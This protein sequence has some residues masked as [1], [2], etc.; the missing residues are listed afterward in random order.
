MPTCDSLEVLEFSA[1]LIFSRTMHELR[2]QWVKLHLSLTGICPP[3]SSLSWAVSICISH[4]SQSQL[5]QNLKYVLEVIADG[6][7]PVSKMKQ[8]ISTVP[9]HFFHSR[10]VI[11]SMSEYSFKPKSR[12]KWIVNYLGLSYCPL[13]TFDIVMFVGLRL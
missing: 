11:L 5:E 4:I 10:M 8:I 12:Q 7:L 2:V 1:G 3:L 6:F 9:G 13:I